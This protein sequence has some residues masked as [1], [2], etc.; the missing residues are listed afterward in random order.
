MLPL[1][2][3]YQ[4]VKKSGKYLLLHFTSLTDYLWLLRGAT[5]ALA[6]IRKNAMLYLAAAVSDFYLPKD[7]IV[8]LD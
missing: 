4:S 5:Q 3:Q 1:L 8:S 2:R 6:T 7:Q